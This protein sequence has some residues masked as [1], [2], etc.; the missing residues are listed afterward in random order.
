MGTAQ[1][2]IMVLFNVWNHMLSIENIQKDV[3]G[4]KEVKQQDESY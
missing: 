1:R 2:K 4:G 3:L